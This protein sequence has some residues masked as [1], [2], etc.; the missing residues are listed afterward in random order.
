MLTTNLTEAIT[1][2]GRVVISNLS[3]QLANAISNYDFGFATTAFNELFKNDASVVY[4]ILIDS[5]KQAMFYKISGNYSKKQKKFTEGEFFETSDLENKKVQDLL[6]NKVF[7]E[8]KLIGEK[9]KDDKF[10]IEIYRLVQP[11][12]I[13]GQFWGVVIIAYS[14]ETLNK[15][16]EKMRVDFLEKIDNERKQ[17]EQS[18][19]TQK[20]FEIQKIEKNLAEIKEAVINNIKNNAVIYFVSF[21]I[22]GI[23]LAYIFSKKITNPIIK[24]TKIGEKLAAGDLKIENLEVRS[25]DE[26]GVLT[27]AFNRILDSQ[28]NL[29]QQALCI[30]NDNLTDK[31]LEIKIEGDLGEAFY[32]M[33]ANLKNLAEQAQI[34][35]NDDLY[36]E[37]LSTDGAGTLGK[38]FSD[39]IVNLR[40]LTKQA[41]LIANDE[42]YANELSTSGSGTLSKAFAEMTKNLRQFAGLAKL[43]ADGEL[44]NKNLKIE[45]TGVL[46]NA[47]KDMIFSLKKLSEQADAIAR[48][49]LHHPIL[50][51]TVK[52]ELGNNFKIMTNNLRNLISDLENIINEVKKVAVTIDEVSETVNNSSNEFIKQSNEQSLLTHDTD[53]AL[54][55]FSASV[56]EIDHNCEKSREISNNTINAVKNGL[57]IMDMV[58]LEMENIKESIKT[59]SNKLDTLNENSQKIS[60]IVEIITGISRKISLLALNAAI[61]SARAGEAG[62]GFAIVADEVN[63]LSEQ[64]HKS[65]KEISLLVD[66]IKVQTSLS[67]ESM[68]SGRTLINKGVELVEQAAS[69]FNVINSAIEETNNSIVEI[70]EAVKEQTSVINSIV[71][72]TDKLKNIS[73]QIL[74]KSEDLKSKGEA[75]K[76]NT[77]SL[78]DVLKKTK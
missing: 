31:S 76:K 69:S 55:E 70:S 65:V 32:K 21:T 2:K 44:S 58:T 66:T 41:Q 13:S 62:R 5:N 33:A 51:E 42:L 56:Q 53:T 57:K 20:T 43:I 63:K 34:I 25:K 75:L 18:A 52:G 67:V 72:S 1:Q 59:T 40:N 64:T 37:R 24:M 15:Q 16:L 74:K 46:S 29:M 23:F 14:L 45:K 10:G 12:N 36:N 47:F 68:N 22:P 73:A 17:L 61:E 78:V 60:N 49:E 38:A 50:S 7:S 6:I 77:K 71:A 9:M 26:I 4:A 27:A 28:R 11:I 30:S 8:K 3:G 35:A 39:V 19:D 54:T 48:G